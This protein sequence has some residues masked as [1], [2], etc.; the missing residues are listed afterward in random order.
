MNSDRTPDKLVGG[1]GVG[2]MGNPII[3]GHP[4]LYCVPMARQRKA[5]GPALATSAISVCRHTEFAIQ[6]PSTVFRRQK[7]TESES[8]LEPAIKEGKK[9][10]QV[11]LFTLIA[12]MCLLY[13]RV[14]MGIVILIV[15]LRTTGSNK[16]RF[17]R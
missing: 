6:V 15:L 16:P 9:M 13:P 8:A 14:A 17:G 3:K 7:E 5:L 12:S 1:T 2:G 4:V 10:Y 11:P